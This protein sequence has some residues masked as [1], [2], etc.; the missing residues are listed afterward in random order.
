MESTAAEDAAIKDNTD[1][2]NC[3]KFLKQNRQ[4]LYYDEGTKILDIHSHFVNI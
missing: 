2:A 1:E 3:K 4:I